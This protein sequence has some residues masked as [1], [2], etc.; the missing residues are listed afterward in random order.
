MFWEFFRILCFLLKLSM[1][2]LVV[3]YNNSDLYN[4]KLFEKQVF[5]NANRKMELISQFHFKKQ[6]LLRF[7]L[8]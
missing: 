6:Y 5:F 4:F 7:T 2:N 1:S 8:S 3:K